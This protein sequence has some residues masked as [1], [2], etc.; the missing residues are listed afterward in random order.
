[1]V[2][3]AQREWLVGSD[4]V[5]STLAAREGSFGGLDGGAGCS[6]SDSW[7]GD[8]TTVTTLVLRKLSADGTGGLVARL[9]DC[10]QEG[11]SEGDEGSRLLDHSE[12][13]LGVALRV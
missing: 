8:G 10:K 4:C 6:S 13:G 11:E 1:V 2:G 3:C 7:I 5:S 12:E 9:G